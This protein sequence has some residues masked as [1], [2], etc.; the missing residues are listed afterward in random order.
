MKTL[1][2]T[3]EKG[4]TGKSLIATQFA[5]Y[6]Q[7]FF[8]LRVALI[9]LDQQQGTAS[10]LR[11]S[12]KVKKAEVPSEDF[13]LRKTADVLRNSKFSDFTVFAGGYDQLVAVQD[14]T[15]KDEIE[16]AFV[17][18]VQA[19]SDH[20]DLVIIDTN[21]NNDIRS[22]AALVACTHLV[23]PMQISSECLSGMQLLINRINGA[24]PKNPD[25]GNGFLGILANM[26][27]QTDYQKKGIDNFIAEVGNF[28]VQTEK[29]SFI[30][31]NGALKRDDAGNLLMCRH[32]EFCVLK[33]HEKFKE[34]QEQ[35]RP[36]WELNNSDNAFREMKQ[37]FFA[38]IEQMHVGTN[39][40]N[41]PTEADMA[42]FQRVSQKL[43][44]YAGLAIRQY[45]MTGNNVY[46]PLVAPPDANALTAIRKKIPLSALGP[47][48]ATELPEV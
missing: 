11:R 13:F 44:R 14:N 2:I 17:A 31:E 7:H 43:G 20:F 37:A 12:D 4:G 28:M 26:Y 1:T 22:Q 15:H 45:W 29:Y 39:P 23:C 32:P 38:I 19:L 35:A 34:A 24:L 42:L 46:M 27:Q 10:T 18:S 30:R 6:A 8:G 16:A 21:P 41:K 33:L 9:D 3:I 48:L 40:A 47:S 36:L 5:F 25:L